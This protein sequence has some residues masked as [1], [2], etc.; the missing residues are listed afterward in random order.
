MAL[1]KLMVSCLLLTGLGATA[2]Y[3]PR[4]FSS[5]M[6]CRY[7]RQISSICIQLMTCL[8]FP[9][10]AAIPPFNGLINSFSAPPSAL[11]T[12]PVLNF[13][14]RFP[15]W[16]TGSILSSHCLQ[17]SPKN[18]LSA[19]SVSTNGRGLGIT[20]SAPYQPMAEE[21]ITAFTWFSF[22]CKAFTS[23]ALL[24]M[25]LSIISY[26]TTACRPPRPLPGVQY[27]RLFLQRRHQ[28]FAR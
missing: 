10:T 9:N 23:R 8:P 24:W 13:T 4:I 11:R 25:R 1:A 3:T 5:S 21:L 27:N 22:S 6:A 12:I 26:Q 14:N 7:I 19:G 28:W 2:L 17:V 20:G 16:L 15:N 18:A